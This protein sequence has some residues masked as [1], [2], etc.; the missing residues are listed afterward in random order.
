MVVKVVMD[1]KCLHIIPN[2][3]HS[4]FKEMKLNPL[5]KFKRDEFDLWVRSKMKQY[6]KYKGHDVTL[7][8]IIDNEDFDED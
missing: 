4:N 8:H 5:H 1:S 7:A 2:R 3:D 6:D